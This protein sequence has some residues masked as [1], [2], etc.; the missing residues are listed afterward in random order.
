MA[1]LFSDDISLSYSSVDLAEIQ[2][3]LNEDLE[4]LSRWANNC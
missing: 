4:K 3:I 2:R 1:R